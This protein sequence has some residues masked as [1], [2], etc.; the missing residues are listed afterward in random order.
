MKIFTSLTFCIFFFL[1]VRGQNT[2]SFIVTDAASGEKLPGVSVVIEKTQKGGTT[3]SAG[4]IIL[5]NIPP[6]PR[7]FSFSI[8]GY[9][10]KTVSYVFP[11]SI[12][13]ITVE[14]ERAEEEKMEEVIVSSSRTDSRI[15]NTHSR[16]EVLGA[17][18]VQEE[19]G[20]K[21][22]E[23]AGLLSDVA[24][25]QSQ[26]TSSVTGNIDLRIQGLPG[27]YTQLLRNGMPLFGGY[28]SSFSI[29]QIPPLDLKQIE[30]IKG[31]SSTL[32]G[33]G[34]IAGMINII[35]KKPVMGVEE[36]YLLLSQST[37]RESNINIY[38]SDR[39][40]KRGYT[41]FA[42]G[43]YQKQRDLNKDGFSEVPLIENVFIHP[44]FFIYP[45]DNN[46]ISVGI[47]SIFEERKGGD[48]LVLRNR[49]DSV[50]QFIIENHSYR[51]TMDAV[52]ERKINRTDKF[53]L[54]GIVNWYY[55]NI[56]TRVFGM[57]AKQLS[58]FTEGA[59]VM[60]KTKH[61]LVAGFN[62]SGENFIKKLPDST[63]IK[64]YHFF[65]L[66]LFL[67]DDWR[68]HSKFIV[69]GGL[70]A[71]FHNQY[72]V[73]VL[74]RISLLYKINPA[75]TTR[76]GG[77]LGYKIPTL[78]NSEVDERDYYI[79]RF[80]KD[81]A[82]KAERSEGINWDINFKKQAGNVTVTVNQSF[83][84][85]RIN[86]P[87]VAFTPPGSIIYYTE[88]KPLVTKGSETWLQVAYKGLQ[89]YLGY[90]LTDARRKYDPLHPH[91]DLSARNKFASVVSYEFSK[92]FR[93][94][95]EA[96]YTGRQYL[97]DG[98]QTPSFPTMAGMIRYDIGRFSL[99]LNGENLFDYRQ[100]KKEA[101]L[102]PPPTNPGF[103][104][105]WAPIEGRVI[106]L[107]LRIKL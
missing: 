16:V 65:T 44:T 11:I 20:V 94:G 3:D 76:L 64:D 62:V 55:R 95:L 58:Y 69:E 4:V 78:F 63:S 98:S 101:I 61:D 6:G 38:L 7:K 1:V 54:K 81:N 104:Q 100:T 89:A 2:V 48:M 70:R 47:N 12:L 75:V 80:D 57:K 8:I 25:I 51:N 93:A 79:L 42:G 68:V 85:T 29:L 40:R 53:T 32:Y 83:Y 14:M 13:S 22:A 73:F 9:E 82:I 87:L 84:I 52:W 105:I 33:G 107:T 49:R 18:E 26:Q 60:K 91:L 50:H 21:P 72:G 66:G 56:T 30:I 31:A 28:A 27:G 43:T 17:E 41:F 97:E 71:D 74:P 96:T 99:A 15:E 86:H 10:T 90:T 88:T 34:A 46:S 23:I 77:G 45:N 37:L 35:S 106:S 5:K 24:G 59:Y 92:H 102:I 19:S 36:R 103:K 39:D 67:Q